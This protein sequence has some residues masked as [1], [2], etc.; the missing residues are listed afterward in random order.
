MKRLYKSLDILKIKGPWR[1][2]WA[3]HV[4]IMGREKIIPWQGTETP[5]WEVQF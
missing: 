1:L 4:D 5:V 3:A 2:C